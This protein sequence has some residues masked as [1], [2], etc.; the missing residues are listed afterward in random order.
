MYSIF[1]LKMRRAISQ[2]NSS[3]II[4]VSGSELNDL[5]GLTDV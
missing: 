4:K 5:F 2:P 1:A 3:G